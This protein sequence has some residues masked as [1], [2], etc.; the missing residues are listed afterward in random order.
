MYQFYKFLIFPTHTFQLERGR[1][2]GVKGQRSTG[3][4]SIGT[5]E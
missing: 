1:R 3:N 5:N 2:R 4:V